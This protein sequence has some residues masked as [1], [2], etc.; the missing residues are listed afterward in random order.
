MPISVRVT[1]SGHGS[2]TKTGMDCVYGAVKE[3]GVASVLV[4]LNKMRLSLCQI[5]CKEVWPQ[6]RSDLM[7]GGVAS[8]VF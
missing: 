4:S 5:P 7:K 1:Y 3:V 6:C 2:F 8:A